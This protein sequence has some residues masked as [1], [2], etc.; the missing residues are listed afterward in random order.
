MSIEDEINEIERYIQK[1]E[2]NDKSIIEAES[3][4]TD[5]VSKGLIYDFFNPVKKYRSTMYSPKIIQQEEYDY[6]QQYVK[7][8]QK[9]EQDKYLKWKEKI[10][11]S[12]VEYSKYELKYFN[13]I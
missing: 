8:C 4:I 6:F 11:N 13:V 9:E 12:G 1:L 7:R 3:I 5:G 10:I 2:M